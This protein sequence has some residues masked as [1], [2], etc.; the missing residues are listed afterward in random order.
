MRGKALGKAVKLLAVAAVVYGLLF[1]AWV[2][3]EKNY[4]E[5]LAQAENTMPEGGTME[6]RQLAPGMT[7][8][9]WPAGTN[10]EGYML[11]ILRPLP[12]GE[13]QVLVR[14]FLDGENSCILPRFPRETPVTIRISSLHH[15]RYP[16]EEEAR[17]RFGERSL[18]ITGVFQPPAVRSFQH[19]VDY[20]EDTLTISMELPE[21]G[22]CRMYEKS[23]TGDL[24]QLDTLTDGE[25]VL[26]FGDDA[27]FPIPGPQEQRR[28]AFDAYCQG[29]NYIY[30]GMVTE[31]TAVNREDFLGT[32]LR[33]NCEDTGHNQF[34]FSWNETKGERY[35][36]QQF[37]PDTGLWTTVYS[38][39]QDGARTYTTGHLPRY[40]SY[41][42]RVI[43]LG[44]QTLPD[45]VYAAVPDEQTVS[46]GASLIYSTVWPIKS[47]EV[48][49]APDRT[50]VLGTVPACSAHCVLD[51]EEGL[52]R[53][54]FQNGFGYI[55]SSYC[56][57]NLPDYIGDICAYDI[58]NSYKSQFMAHGY[59]IPKV[60]GEMLKGYEQVEQGYDTYFVPLLYPTA[61]K[62][63]QAAF[64]AKEQ[65]FRLKIYD[66]FRPQNTTKEL[67]D[68]FTKLAPEALPEQTYSGKPVEDLP[69][70]QEGEV[71]T[72]ELLVTDRG[73]YTLD[74]FL[75]AKG[76]RHNQGVALDLT[77][78]DENGWELE[79]QTAIHDL[80]WYSELKQ[81]NQNAKTLSSIMLGCGFNGLSSEW[82]HFQDD[83]IR[84]TVELPFQQEGIQAAG[85]VAD[86]RGW[87]YRTADGT[88][89]TACTQQMEGTYYTFD[90]QGYLQ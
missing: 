38:V 46:T 3:V 17:T 77:I 42:Y 76:S 48:Y 80:S 59:E 56:M 22:T 44:G 60:T 41:A 32:Q 10:A 21:N 68:I 89:Y 62:L 4:R 29:E 67:Y 70:M 73:R 13:N 55:D 39:T 75:A 90:E 36:F 54:R 63:E 47:L 52:F 83:E 2:W 7:Q 14:S 23:A 26:H 78:E 58:T 50:E 6:L 20:D 69:E 28:F 8:L 31:E 33:L 64:A 19:Y 61:K 71:L 25:V 84:K 88:F 87:R 18:E 85:W 79:M 34:I 37:D 5:P 57:I 16:F 66:S 81:N 27:Q 12:G 35:E 53:I 65:G 72:Y 24:T 40:G 45:S 86:D 82:W 1:G 15:Y 49:G 11:E 30:Y 43:A 74:F 9:T 51:E